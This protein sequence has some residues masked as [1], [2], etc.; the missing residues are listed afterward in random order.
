MRHL[1]FSLIFFLCCLI[2]SAP[3]AV[4]ASPSSPALTA[5]QLAALLRGNPQILLD[6][7]KEHGEELLAIVQDGANKKRDKDLHK[8]WQED[9]AKPK[10][11]DLKGHIVRGR[12]DAP[13]TIVAYSDFTCSF[14]ARAHEALNA[15]MAEYPNDIRYVF[16]TFSHGDDSIE[17]LTASY[18]LAAAMQSRDKAWTL[19][20]MMFAARPDIIARGR[21]A[22]DELAVKAGLDV[23]KL[24]AD[25]TKDA[26]IT[27]LDDDLAEAVRLSVDGTPTIFI[28]NLTLRGA[29]TA[30]QLEAAFRMARDAAKK[31]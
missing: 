15:L 10:R 17:T 13:V 29:P 14:C 5:E 21:E 11:F 23:K 25:C 8:K 22:L 27:M 30:G 28:N 20:D 4:A 31:K 3:S 16:K 1:L 6:V 24:A 9:L 2:G 7:L 12:A 19:H 26:V 18:F